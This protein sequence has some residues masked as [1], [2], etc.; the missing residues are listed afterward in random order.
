MYKRFI[1]LGDSFT[2]GLMD[3]FLNG[4]FRG[5]A[6]RLA[7]TLADLDPEF[8]Y[9]NL[10]VRGKVIPQVVQEQFPQAFHYITGKE[11]LV[12]FHAG[13]NDVLRPKYDPDITLPAYR[14][15]VYELSRS[16][17]TIMLFTVLEKTGNTGRGSKVWEKRFR[18]FNLNVQQ[19]ADEVGA[20]IVDGNQDGYPSD[21][22]YLAFDRLHLNRQGHHVVAQAVQEKLG[23]PFDESWKHPLPPA[24]PRPKVVHWLN[25]L[26]WFMLFAL[27]WLWRR[28]RRTSSGDG[29]AA[30]Y[31]TPTPW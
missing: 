30:K 2:E 20:I 25:T 28:I 8:T 11:T 4:K 15:A 27:P 22:R 1:A 14:D 18:D 3:E 29:R 17:A 31:P 21:R 26:A 10:A 19:I 9:M 6:D 7:D 13:A 12:S 5:W 23:L 16:G 24:K